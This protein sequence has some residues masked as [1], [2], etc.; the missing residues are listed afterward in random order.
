MTDSAVAGPAH[1]APVAGS[2]ASSQASL[3]SV[4]PLAVATSIAGMV[5]LMLTTAW[6]IGTSPD[7]VHYIRTAR[8][9]LGEPGPAGSAQ[10]A[11]FYPWLLAVLGRLSG[12][13]PISAA[14]GLNV[15]VFGANI[16][17]VGLVV[18]HATHNIR[19]IWLAAA[20]TVLA[21]RP[22]LTVHAYA[23]SEPVFLTVGLLGLFLLG[24]YLQEGRLVLLLGAGAA[25]GLAFLTRYA[26]AALLL[27]GGLALLLFERAAWPRRVVRAALFGVVA[28]LP[29]LA[30]MWRNM[31]ATG[32]ATG[33]ELV[34]HPLTRAQIWQGVYTTAD[35]LFIPRG[36]PDAVRLAAW[37][38]VGGAVA[39]VVVRQVVVRDRASTVPAVLALF[40]ATY[41][42]FLATSISLLDANTEL[43][44]RILMPAF[45]AVVPV[46]CWLADRAWPVLQ[47]VRPALMALV[48]AAAAFCGV[49]VQAGVGLA[50]AGRENGWGFSSR[51]WAESPTIDAIEA[52]PAGTVVYS[53]APEIVY[54]HTGRA[55]EA[56]PRKIFLM[57]GRR[58]GQFAGQLADTG[59]RLSRTCGVIAYFRTLTDQKSVPTEAE[60]QSRL[61]LG[62]RAEGR[63]GALLSASTCR[64]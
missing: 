51:A 34:L 47:R 12:V 41:A 45:V 52:L 54:L 33:R 32:T 28:L 48:V 15:A 29:M 35:W 57:N 64:P 7:S 25:I 56:L 1:D 63:D 37:A 59:D 44:D 43:D 61:S 6:G 4:L 3:R 10:F 58:N 9:W 11:P 24:R 20:W 42:A 60:L 2:R 19:W 17:L 46:L 53:N 26:A 21:A 50:A 62:V 55:A 38:V 23:L 5:L 40:V 14:R 8:Q 27:S 18:R 16:L 39:F 30:W 22:V 31:S 13:D 49:T 36:A